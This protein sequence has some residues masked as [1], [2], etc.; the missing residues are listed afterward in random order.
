MKMIDVRRK[1]QILTCI[2]RNLK[3]GV[4]QIAQP[5]RQN[6]S[7]EAPSIYLPIPRVELFKKSVYYYVANLWNDLPIHI[8]LLNDMDSFKL[9]INKII[10]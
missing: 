1:N 3:N 4:I 9:E 5:I 8:R 10:I 6:R 2:W 7:A